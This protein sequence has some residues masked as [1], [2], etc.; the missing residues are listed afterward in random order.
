MFIVTKVHQIQSPLSGNG[1][2][3]QLNPFAFFWCFPNTDTFFWRQRPEP[4]T[5]VDVDTPQIYTPA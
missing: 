4:Q 3:I 2:Y 5:V 1:P